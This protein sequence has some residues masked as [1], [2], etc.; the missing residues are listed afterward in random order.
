MVQSRSV[1]RSAPFA[2][3]LAAQ[4]SVGVLLPGRPASG[5]ELRTLFQQVKPSVVV[6]RT[7][8]EVVGGDDDDG[9]TGLKLP[10]TRAGAN[11]VLRLDSEAGETRVSGLASGVLITSDGQIL[12]AAHVVQTAEKVEVQFVDGTRE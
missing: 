12:T 2:L 7:E 1:L 4:L 11:S 3:G 9:G 10:R 5:Q 6:I 8:E